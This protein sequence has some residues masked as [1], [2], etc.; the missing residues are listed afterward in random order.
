MNTIKKILP[1]LLAVALLLSMTA[2][3]GTSAKD[4]KPLLAGEL[5]A[6]YHGILDDE[7]AKKTDADEAYV[8]EV[9]QD[10]LDVETESFMNAAE[11]EDDAAGTYSARIQA[12]FAELY[13]QTKW[14]IGDGAEKSTDC[15]A[16][17][18][19]I[20]P[21]DV[22]DKLS[23][24]IDEAEMDPDIEDFEVAWAEMFVGCLEEAATD[25]GYKDPVEI[26]CEV[27]KDSSDNLWV[28]DSEAIGDVY[29][30]LIPY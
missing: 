16:Y 27:Y 25:V 3:G 26:S 7:F 9:Y 15:Y 29:A 13:P 23:A 4:V 11:I 17:T 21:L 12:V 22:M 5:E 8:A 2:C 10:T 6:N 28:T 1:L 30:E 24:L 19:T 18:V 14:E 20:Y